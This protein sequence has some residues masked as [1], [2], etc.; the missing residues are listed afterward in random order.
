[1]IRALALVLGFGPA[2][3]WAETL[4]LPAGA[5][6]TTQSATSPDALRVATAPFDG[7]LPNIVAEGTL[8]RSAWTQANTD[9]TTLALLTPL[10]TQ[11]QDA[12]FE[13]FFTCADIQCGGFDFR[14]ALDVVAAPAMQVNL[15][16][17][18]YWAGK[19]GDE[20][21]VILISKIADTAYI[22]ID[23]IAASDAA[24]P[25][26]AAAQPTKT[27][28]TRTA[29]TSLIGALEAD[30]RVVLSDLTFA[31]GSSALE[32]GDY[33]SLVSL[34]T[35]L[36][37][38]PTLLVALVG[39]TDTAG[40]L[41]GNIALSRERANSV[42]QRLITRHGVPRRQMDAE[43]MGY[44]APVANNLFEAGREANRRVE[45]IIVGVAK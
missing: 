37:E 45:V 39:H 25:T 15:A 40:S 20:H 16:D 5:T 19:R 35:Y 7:A 13:Q 8:T 24:A 44:L 34:A 11:L 4:V 14:F 2:A 26:A 36:K 38:Q 3:T 22:Q 28:A 18:Q 21:A 10:R 31:P 27:I 32:D 43:G 23:R 9:T 12:G 41:D 42:M 33:A 1:M 30:G 29:P 17:Y 6:Q